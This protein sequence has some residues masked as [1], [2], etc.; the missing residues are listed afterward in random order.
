MPLSG[1]YITDPVQIFNH[2]KNALLA[3]CCGFVFASVNVAQ[4]GH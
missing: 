1:S 4:Y 2:W 3:K